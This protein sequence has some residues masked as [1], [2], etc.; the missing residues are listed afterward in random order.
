MITEPTIDLMANLQESLH[1]HCLL[2]GKNHPTGYHLSFELTGDNG[3]RA[4]FD[5]DSLY[6]GYNGYMHG[7]VIS[8]LLDA[9]MTNCLFAHGRKAVTGILNIRFVSP[10]LTCARATV[11]AWIERSDIPLHYMQAALEQNGRRVARASATFME[12]KAGDLTAGES[13]IG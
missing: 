7:G 10:V 9:A 3:V 11:K 12:I 8:S 1:T 4:S 6:Q 2:C 5:C 13:G